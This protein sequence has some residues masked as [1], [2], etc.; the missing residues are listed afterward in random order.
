MPQ[1]LIHVTLNT[2]YS[3]GSSRE[4]KE[5]QFEHTQLLK[6]RTETFKNISGLPQKVAFAPLQVRSR[7]WPGALKNW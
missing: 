5:I 2:F 6:P 7:A 4:F 3:E 1:R